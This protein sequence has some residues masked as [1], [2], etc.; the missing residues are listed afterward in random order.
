[1]PPTY[2]ELL[3]Q[4]EHQTARADALEEN[5]RPSRFLDYLRT[6]EEILFATFGVEPA[7]PTA[8]HTTSVNGKY[9][10]QRL[11]PWHDFEAVHTVTFN[12]LRTTF[13]GARLFPALTDVLGVGRDLSPAAADELDL[14]PFIRAAI[15]KP[16]ARILSEY[17]RLT[18]SPLCTRIRFQSNSFGLDLNQTALAAVVPG[19][20]GTA[21]EDIQPPPATS[22]RSPVI[23][24]GIPDRWCVRFLPDDSRTHML[25]GEYKAAHKLP[26]R[27][28]RAVLASG[29][30]EDFFARAINK[31]KDREASAA[32]TAPGERKQVPGDVLVARV[33]CQ[34]YHYMISS[35][36]Q[37]GYVASGDGLIFLR[38]LEGEPQTLDYFWS[39]FPVSQADEDDGHGG[40]PRDVRAPQQTAAAYMTTLCM[41]AVQSAV[42]PMAWIDACDDNLKRWPDP[43]GEAS[44]L[45]GDGG[46]S[47]GAHD[48]GGD[49]GGG[50][51]G[52]RGRGR[53][54][55]SRGGRSSRGGRGS[56]GGRGSRGGHGGISKSGN[57]SAKRPGD[58]GIAKARFIVEPPTLPYC[59]QA[60]LY[61]LCAG[62]P[63]DDRCP[64]VTAHR[65]GRTN[66]TEQK[67]AEGPRLLDGHPLTPAEVRAHVVAQ[68]AQ[69][70]DKDCECLDKWGCFGRY[71]VLFKLTVTGYGYT[72]VAK[73]VQ[74]QHRFVLESEAAVYTDPAMAAFQGRLLPVFLGL[75][76]LVRPLP[77]HS[78]ARVPYLMLLSYAGP[79][80]TSLPRTQQVPAGLDWEAEADRTAAELEAAGLR[81]ED[82]RP[83]NMAWNAEAGR[84]MHLDFDQAYIVRRPEPA[85]PNSAAAPSVPAAQS[86]S[87][88]LAKRD[89]NASYAGERVRRETKQ[90]RKR[91]TQRAK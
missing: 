44:P 88:L 34:A 80:P 77:L 75:V 36:L 48:P 15:E 38:V 59:T 41:L 27:K 87:P 69:N 4:L 47:E 55:G 50:S 33:L 32:T 52:G 66:N 39:V 25:V 31:D 3:H 62:L 73:G 22:Q 79:T 91:E 86:R 78:C 23:R 76:D 8:S 17:L 71:G 14:R 81:N 72:M 18:H 74:A 90:S 26:A 68:L 19:V 6:T 7:L 43:Y 54:R 89:F 65:F 20:A 5:Q 42:R 70:M 30:R 57:S 85:V 61:G 21:S 9:Y 29:P 56:H 24:I 82:L 28:V 45:G 67:V 12:S 2:E 51:N 40:P 58:G 64:N 83:A 63:L 53:G 84:V 35:G 16:A 60:C 46:H 37:F 10:P 11:R 49:N 1:M 13:G